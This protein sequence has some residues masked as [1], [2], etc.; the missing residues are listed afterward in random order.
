M[1]YD[2]LKKNNTLTFAFLLTSILFFVYYLGVFPKLSESYLY[3]FWETDEQC[4]DIDP[5]GNLCVSY[6][7]PKWINTVAPRELLVF[8]SNRTNKE[9]KIFLSFLETSSEKY[10]LVVSEQPAFDIGGRNIRTSLS[11]S[12]LILFSKSTVSFPWS[13]NLFQHK[14]RYQS[15]TISNVI[16]GTDFYLVGNFRY[17]LEGKECIPVALNLNSKAI[18]LS[19][20]RAFIDS[21]I[22]TILLPPW[23]N[24]FLP[25]I[26]VFLTFFFEKKGFFKPYAMRLRGWFVLL[27]TLGGVIWFILGLI[28]KLI[29]YLF[30]T[31]DV[32]INI[33]FDI[34]LRTLGVALILCGI[35]DLFWTKQQP[36]KYLKKK[37]PHFFRFLDTAFRYSSAFVGFDIEKMKEDEDVQRT[38]LG[39]P[40]GIKSLNWLEDNQ[41]KYSYRGRKKQFQALLLASIHNTPSKDFD[42]KTSNF[43]R[44]LIDLVE[45][46]PSLAFQDDVLVFT[47]LIEIVE[48][49]EYIKKKIEP[50]DESQQPSKALSDLLEDCLRKKIFSQN[51]H[52]KFTISIENIKK[53]ST[54]EKED[55]QSVPSS[56]TDSGK[57]GEIKK[58]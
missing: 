1:S 32:N 35:V 6:Q 53:N 50:S 46:Y 9:I 45:D 4:I 39:H 36:Y 38:L 47:I 14:N 10:K 17:C 26:G 28:I 20:W 23:S 5:S 42:W 7:V 58:S 30:Q 27:L 22:K 48:S 31:P 15:Q 40:N 33:A 2:S 34:V 8:F 11:S 52:E 51:V 24:T 16:D 12:E 37:F 13:I 19:P 44:T 25:V 41:R 57:T 21:F 29:D 54:E 55:Q 18:T 49:H 43:L 3:N 56:A